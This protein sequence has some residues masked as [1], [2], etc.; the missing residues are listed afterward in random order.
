LGIKG[1]RPLVGRI[2]ELALPEASPVMAATY[3]DLYALLDNVPDSEREVLRLLAHYTVTT[4]Q[5][6]ARSLNLTMAEI[7]SQILNLIETGLILRDNGE[8]I[9]VRDAL[10]LSAIKQIYDLA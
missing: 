7:E 8:R 10:T 5:F 3:P 4:P 9:A 2:H 1:E 6:L